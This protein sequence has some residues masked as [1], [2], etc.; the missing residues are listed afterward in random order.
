MPM[1]RTKQRNDITFL[2]RRPKAP[3]TTPTVATTGSNAPTASGGS[4]LSFERPRKPAQASGGLNLSNLQPTTPVVSTSPAPAAVQPSRKLEFRQSSTPSASPTPTSTPKAKRSSL[5][6]RPKMDAELPKHSIPYFRNNLELSLENPAIRLDS[7]QS[8]IGSLIIEGAQAFAWETV[9]GHGGLQINKGTASSA[10]EPPSFGRR[11]VAE[12]INDEIIVGL[13]HGSNLR[14]L[15]VASSNDNLR[16]KLHDKSEIFMPVDAG[17]NVMLIS[18][19]GHEFEIRME[20]IDT[21][22]IVGTFSVKMSHVI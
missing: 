13:R 10:V 16:L 1:D 15:I 14:R 11:K 4:K 20:K 3:S 2:R 8:G 21:H 19:I 22:D 18:R 7:R 5:S 17:N 9:S 12:F 6:L